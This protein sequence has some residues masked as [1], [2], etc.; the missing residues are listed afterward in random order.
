MSDP[1]DRT[2]RL[3]EVLAIVACLL[4]TIISLIPRAQ[5]S[6]ADLAVLQ[7]QYG[8]LT[9]RVNGIEGKIDRLLEKK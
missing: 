3:L 2:F 7:E 4:N 6:Q 8:E 1:K 9:R 5:A